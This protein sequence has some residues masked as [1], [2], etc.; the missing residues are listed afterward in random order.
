[1][2]IRFADEM[3]NSQPILSKYFQSLVPLLDI[4]GGMDSCQVQQWFWPFPYQ[5]TLVLPQNGPTFAKSQI[6]DQDQTKMAKHGLFMS[7]SSDCT[8]Y[9]ASCHFG[10][11]NE[12]V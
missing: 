6:S 2:A 10:R 8:W 7:L 11:G 9:H 1:M 4:K 12:V 3:P 5:M